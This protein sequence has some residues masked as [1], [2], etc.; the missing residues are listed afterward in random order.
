[1]RPVA[2]NEL[3]NEVPIIQKPL[4]WALISLNFT[5]NPAGIFVKMFKIN[6]KGTWTTSS[7]SSWCLYCLLRTNFTHCSGVSFVDFE[8]VN[9]SWKST[10]RGLAMSCR[11]QQISE[12]YFGNK[13]Q[14][15]D[16]NYLFKVSNRNTKNRC[17]ICSQNDLVLVFLLST[18]NIFQ[19]FF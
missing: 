17:E 15:P 6:N 13:S 2:W 19:K 16:N 8:Q 7:M 9:T 3:T 11:T 10:K 18:L 4:R 5:T 14:F 1:M 12:I